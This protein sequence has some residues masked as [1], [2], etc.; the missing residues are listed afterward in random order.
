MAAQ[1]VK[2]DPGVIHLS[3]FTRIGILPP[4][5]VCFN[6][7]YNYKLTRANIFRIPPTTAPY[8]EG[9]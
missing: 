4:P 7:V 9:V 8:F 5:E 3:A 1:E 2:D 6:I